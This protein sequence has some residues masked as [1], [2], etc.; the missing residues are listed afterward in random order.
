[1]S[2]FE[3]AE[4]AESICSAGFLPLDPFIGHE[5]DGSTY[6]LE[7]NRRLAAI[8][9]LLNPDL[10][11]VEFRKTWTA[12]SSRLSSDSREAME[13]ISVLVYTDRRNA[14]LLSYIGY[15]HV[16]GVISYVKTLAH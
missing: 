13:Q 6:I 3:I 12:F 15:R 9:L 7:G 5:Q 16:N 4:I 2:N 14:D 1:M 8:K 11:P 10:A